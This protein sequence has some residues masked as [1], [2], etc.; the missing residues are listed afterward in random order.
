MLVAVTLAASTLSGCSAG[1]DLLRGLRGFADD[2][3]TLANSRW[4]PKDLTLPPPAQWPS[5]QQISDEAAR[6]AAPVTEVPPEQQQATVRVACEAADAVEAMGGTA[7]D[8]AN[9]V[10]TRTSTSLSYRTQA[11]ELAAD[12]VEAG[13]ASEQLAILGRVTLCTWASQ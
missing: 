1:D 3:D 12:L 6:L 13:D 10:V 7:E 4:K 8:A 2:T 11:E 9:Y 5:E